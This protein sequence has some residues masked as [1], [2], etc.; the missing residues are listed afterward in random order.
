MRKEPAKRIN[1]SFHE[2]F[3]K[4]NV[5]NIAEFGLN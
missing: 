2:R 1:P 3:K 4:T 5:Y